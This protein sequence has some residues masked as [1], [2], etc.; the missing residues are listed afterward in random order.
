MNSGTV[1]TGSSLL[2]TITQVIPPSL[3]LVVLADQLGVSVGD[4]Y[5]GAIGPSFLQLFLFVLF[6]AHTTF[7]SGGA[8]FQD[9]PD[10]CS[11]RLR[12]ELL[13]NPDVLPSAPL[14]ITDLELLQYRE[15]HAPPAR[16]R[17]AG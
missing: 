13:T 2:V 11:I 8:R 10:L 7:A 6:I 5:L 9:G 1:F 14:V 3:V 15:H 4:M 12:R 16:R 17:G